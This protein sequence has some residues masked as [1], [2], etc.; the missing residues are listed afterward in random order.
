MKGLFMKN[1]ITLLFSFLLLSN[2][3]LESSM[4]RIAVP[5]QLVEEKATL[6]VYMRDANGNQLVGKC[7]LD[8]GCRSRSIL[9]TEFEMTS[10]A[11]EDL[12][13]ISIDLL[14]NDIK[15]DQSVV[16]CFELDGTFQV[17]RIL[18]IKD[19]LLDSDPFDVLSLSFNSIDADDSGENTEDDELSSLAKSLDEEGADSLADRMPHQSSSWFEQYL[20]YAKIIVLMQYGKVQRV[21]RDVSSWW[22]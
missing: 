8:Q 2:S 1:A 9:Q 19:C 13:S 7:H 22:N 5:E 12:M 17:L 10:F 16:V 15:D 14:K 11:D 18:V 3:P 4:F 21:V 6:L 20:L